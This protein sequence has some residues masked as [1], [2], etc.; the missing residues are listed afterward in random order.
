MA[1]FPSLRDALGLA[2]VTVLLIPSTARA[3]SRTCGADPVANTTNVLCAS[4][5]G[6]CTGTSVAM[7][8]NIEVTSGACDFD[9]GGRALTISKTFQMIGS[10][11]I[12]IT[13]VGNVT[14]TDTGKLKARGD[15]V[16]PNGFIISGGLISITSSGSISDAGV[17]D[18]SGDSAG[19]VKLAAVG[20]ITLTAS[21]SIVGTGDTLADEGER[22]ADGG[23]FDA[24]SSA[25]SVLISGPIDLP[26]N[27]QATGGSVFIRAARDIAIHAAIDG[28]GGG[29]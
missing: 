15:F 25:G 5:S 11:Y 12:N 17:M 13:N 6:P 9:L 1:P 7:S 26:G 22:Y 21:S 10:G 19:T 24:R 4:P 16:E 27:N 29:S 18:M 3:V 8:T 2:L 23:N 20:D 28:T 14:I